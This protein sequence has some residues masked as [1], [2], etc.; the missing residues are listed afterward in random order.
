V[1]DHLPWGTTAIAARVATGVIVALRR[2]FSGVG[3]V[4]GT[5]FVDTAIAV[6]IEPV[7]ELFSTGENRVVLIF[8]VAGFHRCPVLV[9]IE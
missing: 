3:G 4:A 7:A 1:E 2:A 8:A 9:D 6:I 5:T